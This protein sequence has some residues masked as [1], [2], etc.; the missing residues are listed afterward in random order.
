VKSAAGFPLLVGEEPVGVMIVNFLTPHSFTA[1]EFDL[2]SLFAQRAAIAI[3]NA[4][5]YQAVWKRLQTASNA[6]VYLSTMSAWAHDAA[7]ETIGLRADAESLPGYISDPNPKV[8]EILERI[9]SKA[10]KV[11]TL[12]PYAPADLNEKQ[13]VHLDQIFQRALSK[14]ENEIRKRYICI[15]SQLA[16]LPPVLV[17]DWLLSEAAG[18]LI[19]NAYKAMPDRGTISLSGYVKGSRIYVKVADTGHGIP[20][21]IQEQL[22]DRR[23]RGPDKVGSGV[24]LVLTR[25]YLNACGGDI[26]LD[27]SDTNGT[28]FTFHLPLAG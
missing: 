27:H 24:G 20:P 9:R 12:I 3:Q 4:R 21:E 19:Q 1:T 23:S 6:A 5:Q 25:I 22:F 26:Y 17:N 7:N 14:H 11:A 10:E 8:L 18:H 13:L 16:N 2:M 28:T 15:D